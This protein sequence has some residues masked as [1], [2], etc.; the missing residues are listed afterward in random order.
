METDG[1]GLA[2]LQ[3]S[4]GERYCLVEKQ[5]PEGYQE[6]KTAV[7][8]AVERRG[9]A[10][11]VVL[12]KDCANASADGAVLRITNR[13]GETLPAT[14]GRAALIYGIAGGLVLLSAVCFLLSA[15]RWKK[16]K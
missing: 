16:E 14:G 6:D 13:A 15:R 12:W 7:V 10:V 9:D 5:A 11:E 1:D 4:A 3:L 2:A 8:F